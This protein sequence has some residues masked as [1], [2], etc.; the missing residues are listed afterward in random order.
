VL[1]LAPRAWLMPPPRS[2]ENEEPRALPA[3][4]TARPVPEMPC[5][6]AVLLDERSAALEAEVGALSARVT[7]LR[8]AVPAA[9]KAQQ[10][11]LC[12]SLSAQASATGAQ[13]A[14]AGVE[15]EAAWALVP[16]HTGEQ[17]ALS[18]TALPDASAR[19][20]GA[21]G[22]LQRVVT[23]VQAFAPQPC[24][25][26]QAALAAVAQGHT[27]AQAA[28][29]AGPDVLLLEGTTEEIED[30]EQAMQGKPLMRQLA[31]S[32]RYAPY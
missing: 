28:Q 11:A 12:A 4:L 21:L 17:L 22:K 3:L 14:A 31:H 24:D 6:A 25:P 23:A 7:A 10:S 1:W 19:L 29:Q 30:A 16:A 18:L 13:L 27:L 20:E 2:A 26:V 32:M 8:E 9:L 15:G 5:P